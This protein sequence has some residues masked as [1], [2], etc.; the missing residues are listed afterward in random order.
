LAISGLWLGITRWRGR[1]PYRGLMRWHHLTGL[2]FGLTVLTWVF[3][4]WLSMNPA[5]LN[6]DQS[7][8]DSESLVFTGTPLIPSD[9][10]PLRALAGSE[11]FEVELFHFARQPFYL[12]TDL[13]G[14][15]SLQYAGTASE[16]NFPSVATVLARASALMPNEKLTH[17]V[18]NEFDEYYYTNHQA[19][20]Q[21]PL[22]V[23]RLQFA[24]PERTRF[25]VDV[26]TGQILGRSTQRNRIYRWLYNGLH[27][28]D[29]KWLRERRPLWDVVVVTFCLGGLALSLI[30]LAAAWRR[31][32]WSAAS[33]KSPAG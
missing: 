5:Q 31:L 13:R 23:L 17:T 9:F 2:V 6:P 19:G 15:Q 32:R 24:D 28:F 10:A 20:Y 22:P 30:G 16:S 27:S 26:Q 14:V 11:I 25:Y 3:S 21:L 12:V 29:F 18:L 1:S 33:W 8:S 7:P 4:G